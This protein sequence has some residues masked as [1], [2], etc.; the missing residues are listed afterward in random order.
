MAEIRVPAYQLKNQHDQLLLDTPAFN[1]KKGCIT[2]VTGPSGSG[3][4]LLIS[5]LFGWSADGVEAALST[6]DGA[7]LMVQDPSQG[8]TPGL[9]VGGHF[10]EVCNHKNWQQ[11]AIEMLASLGLEGHLLNRSVD[12]F[13]G[14]ERQRIMLALLLIREP[15]VLICDEP[16]ASLD[17]MAEVRLWERLAH[18]NKEKGLTLVFITHSLGLIE[19]YADQVLLLDGGKPVF[20]GDT[21]HFFRSAE[22]EVHRRL[23]QNYRLYRHHANQNAIQTRNEDALMH[24]QDVNHSYGD[25]QVLSNLT[26]E[27]HKRSWWWVTGPS[28]CGKTTLAKIIAGI[29]TMDSGRMKFDGQCIESCLRL[30]TSEQR[31]NIQYLFQHGSQ[32]LNPA[33]RVFG[34]LREAFDDILWMEQ[35]LAR[36]RLRD[37]DLNQL[38]SAFSLGEI[39]R[40][41]LVRCL[42][43]RPQV[44]VGDELLSS[45]DLGTKS[46]IIEV[47]DQYRLDHNAAIILITHD[48]KP[49]A[50]MNGQILCLSTQ[51]RPHMENV[52][53]QGVPDYWFPAV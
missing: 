23:L 18:L 14:G 50:L 26:W 4:S 33:L 48:I 15:K 21:A 42:G 31:V 41:N 1:L 37:L 24:L 46:D 11:S 12:T 40:L 22:S 30:R 28:G 49:R 10:S 51:G 13:S 5:S 27:I 36:L 34:Q 19:T 43:R 7:Y 53:E 2:A 8:L 32:A 20:H 45:L 17:A 16:A 35:L 47:L 52:K 3:K 44:I 25:L 39:Q 6:K 38:P 9:S 29:V